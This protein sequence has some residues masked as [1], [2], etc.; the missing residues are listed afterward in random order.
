MSNDAFFCWLMLSLW[1]RTV[2]EHPAIA[3]GDMPE[4]QAQ[5]LLPATQADI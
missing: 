5:R 1:C 4:L 2:I 3:H